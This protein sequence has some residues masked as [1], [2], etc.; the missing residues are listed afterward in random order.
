MSAAPVRAVVLDMD[1]LIL[2]TEPMSPNRSL[3]PWATIPPP[4]V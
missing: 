4:Q 1:G 2:D 3:E